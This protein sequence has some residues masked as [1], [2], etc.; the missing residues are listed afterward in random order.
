MKPTFALMVLARVLAAIAR[1][2]LLAALAAPLPAARAADSKADPMADL[3]KAMAALD[4]KAVVKAIEALGAVGDEKSVKTIV[5]VALKVDEIGDGSRKF[6]PD[7]VNDIFDAAKA[8]LIKTKDEKANKFIIGSLKGHRDWRV[9]AILVQAI[10][11]KPGEE[12]DDALLEAVDDKVPAVAG[13]AIRALAERKVKKAVDPIIAVLEKTEKKRDEPWLDAQTALVS[14]T[15][16]T[17]IARAGD[18]KRWWEANK[19]TFDPKKA[20]PARGPGETVLREAPKI[21]GK[22]VLSKRVVF[23]L[24]ISGSMLAKD[25]PGEH[26][27]KGRTVRPDE[28]EI[29]NTIPEGRMRM[30]RLREAMKACIESLPEDTKFTIVTFGTG[31]NL[32]NESLVP[33]TPAVKQQAI[34]YIMG[35][36]PRGFTWTDTALE[37][38]FS[39][40][41]ANTFYLFSDGIPQRDV[42]PA[43]KQSIFIDRDEICE[44][45]KELN[46]LRKVKIHTIGI[47]EA[48]PHFMA[49][50]AAENGGTVTILK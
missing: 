7:E 20:R 13:E 10:A 34:D 45:V 49:R 41:E 17:D 2:A 32:W 42:D 43:T 29:W 1:V 23:I 28:T 38:A 9:R 26:G 31:A 3:Q 4:A 22:E 47:G 40:P 30:V 19:S 24:D 11:K 36:E 25:I 48:D 21:F 27:E 50:L 44:K 37:L 18:W 12:A 33:A 15:G 35:I 5:Q 46:R 14:L 39:V 8:A 6:K 16:V